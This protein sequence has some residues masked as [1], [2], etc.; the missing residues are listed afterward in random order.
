VFLHVEEYPPPETEHPCHGSLPDLKLVTQPPTQLPVTLAS[1]AS[2]ADTGDVAGAAAVG[3]VRGDTVLRAIGRGSRFCG[4]ADCFGAWT[5]TAGSEEVPPSGVVAASEPLRPQSSSPIEEK[6]TAR[7]VTQR[8]EILITISSQM[9]RQPIPGKQDITILCGL[10]TEASR[11]PEAVRYVR[12]PTTDPASADS[13]ERYATSNLSALNSCGELAVG[14]FDRA[15]ASR[16]S[17][18]GS[19]VMT[20]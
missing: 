9:W 17:S 3:D 6:A 12:P 18:A 1:L 16:R 8:D 14:R 11:K 20:P 5:T 4:L 13:V 7:L 2:L 15:L 10:T 19:K